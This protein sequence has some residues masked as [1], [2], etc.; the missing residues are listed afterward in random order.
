M[1][2]QTL[3]EKGKEVHRGKYDYSLVP[4]TFVTSDKLTIICPDHGEFV[5]TYT[6]HINGGQGCPICNGRQRYTTES[7]IK[8]CQGLENI[9]NIDFSKVNYVTYGNKVTFVC[10]AKDEN[11]VEHGEF[12]MKPGHFFHGE[13]CPKCRYIK[14]AAGRRRSLEEVIQE[15]RKVHGDRY[16]YSKVTNYKNDR[17]NYTIVCPKHG[18]FQQSFNRHIKG[19]QGCPICG[20]ELCNKKRAMT[21]EEF[22]EK[23]NKVHGGKYDYS[24]VEYVKSDIKVCITCP[25][26]GDFWQ[27]PANHLFNQGCPVCKESKLEKSVRMMLVSNSIEFIRE[28]SPEWLGR[29]RLDFYLPDYK[30]AIEC[31][32]KQHFLKEAGWG[33]SPEGLEVLQ[34]RDERKK[35][36][37]KENGVKVLYYSD[38]QIEFPYEVVTTVEELLERIKDATLNS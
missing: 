24:K 8:K 4:D 29:Q 38:L 26:H 15:A 12:Q 11:G 2:K 6:K 21:R 14:S 17:E 9:E 35:V 1:D 31:Q 27:T 5:K 23:A 19:K 33:R 22:I 30:I 32:G 28:Y 37:C 36:L 16:D 18:E 10:H 3:I 13:R 7:F 34:E 25:E 20:R